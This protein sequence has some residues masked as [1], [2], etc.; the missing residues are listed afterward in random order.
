M[1]DTIGERLDWTDDTDIKIG[2]TDVVLKG[3][4]PITVLREGIFRN[5]VLEI[6]LRQIRSE[7]R[8]WAD[9][10]WTPKVVV[11][12]FADKIKFRHESSGAISSFL[13]GFVGTMLLG[14]AFE[15]RKK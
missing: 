14:S 11:A 7:D 4:T 8:I 6:K 10:R 1:F 5:K 13:I 12:T 3:S 15:N 2:N 9:G